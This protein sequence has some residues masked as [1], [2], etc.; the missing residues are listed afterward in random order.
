MP[1]SGK[2]FCHRA[3][4][5]FGAHTAKWFWEKVGSYFKRNGWSVKLANHAN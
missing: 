2:Y 5:N 3:E 1:G 4:F